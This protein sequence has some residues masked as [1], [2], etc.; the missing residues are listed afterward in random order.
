MSRTDMK[1][2]VLNFITG[3]LITVLVSVVIFGGVFLLVRYTLLSFTVILLP[4]LSYAIYMMG[5]SYR[6]EWRRKRAN[7]GR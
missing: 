3:L 2:H 5:K 7:R 1:D 4:V 6:E